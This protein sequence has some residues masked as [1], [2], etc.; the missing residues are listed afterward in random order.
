MNCCTLVTDLLASL[1]LNTVTVHEMNWQ[2]V[3]DINI[4]TDRSVQTAVNITVLVIKSEIM[5]MRVNG[6][7]INDMEKA[8]T[9]DI[10]A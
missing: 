2:P 9:I 5:T 10:N 8:I 3:P 6:L 1:C 7:T 4:A